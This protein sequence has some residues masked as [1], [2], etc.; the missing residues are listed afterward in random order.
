VLR[1]LI[2]LVGKFV[3]FSL[4]VIGG[5]RAYSW[6]YGYDEEMRAWAQENRPLVTLLLLLSL[7]MYAMYVWL[8]EHN[9]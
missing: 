7:I 6:L 2:R 5:A 1:W 9:E 4:A 8:D 3:L